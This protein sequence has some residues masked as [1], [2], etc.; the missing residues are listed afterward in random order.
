MSLARA[1]VTPPGIQVTGGPWLEA[2]EITA[3]RIGAYR[4]DDLLHSFRQT[5]GL[6]PAGTPQKGW[7]APISELRGHFTGHYLS[8]AARA[9][10]CGFVELTPNIERVVTGLRD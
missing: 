9:I 6:A 1:W 3:K 10:R 8:A 4:P 7:E 2:Q 5:A